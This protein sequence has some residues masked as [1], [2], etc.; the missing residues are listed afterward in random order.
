M[1]TLNIPLFYRRQKEKRK[2]KIPKLSSFAFWSDAIMINTQCHELR[3]PRPNFHSPKDVRAIEIRL[4]LGYTVNKDYFT[5]L[6]CA[7]T[8]FIRVEYLR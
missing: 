5:S 6:I 2:R 8:M 3:M 1:G 7:N 4:Y